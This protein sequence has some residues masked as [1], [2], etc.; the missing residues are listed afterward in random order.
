MVALVW[1]VALFESVTQEAIRAAAAPMNTF[2][3]YCDRDDLNVCKRALENGDGTNWKLE[4][5][6]KYRPCRR[7][8]YAQGKLVTPMSR[9]AP[10]GGRRLHAWGQLLPRFLKTPLIA[11][12]VHNIC[13]ATAAREHRFGRSGDRHRYCCE[14]QKQLRRIFHVACPC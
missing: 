1:W 13:C 2:A 11:R 4:A 8:R 3:A 10:R 12:R 6:L 9:L 14:S 7:G 5:S